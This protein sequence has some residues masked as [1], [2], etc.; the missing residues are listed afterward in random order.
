[1]PSGAKKRKAAKKKKGNQSNN[2][3]NLSS[4]SAN[5]HGDEDV[6][7]QDDKGSDVGEVSSPASQDHH[8]HETLLTEGEEEEIEKGGDLSNPPSAGGLKTVSGPE[9]KVL[10]SVVRVERGI[11]IEDEL[12]HRDETVEHDE[13]T[14]KSYDG[15]SSGGSSSR[16][17]S[18]SDDES[19]GIKNSQAAM[20]ISSVVDSSKVADSLSAMSVDSIFSAPTKESLE[21]VA[22]KVSVS[23]EHLGVDRNSPTNITVA[24]Y[25][26]ES[27]AQE[28]AGEKL[29]SVEDK[30]GTSMAFVYDA[31]ERKEEAIVRSVQTTATISDPK[32]C[33]PQE[34]DDKLTL[35]YN[36]P[37]APADNGAE[38]KKDSGVTQP[39]LVPS[40]HPVD[41]TSWK[42]CCGLFEVFSG[43]GA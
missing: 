18:S 11:K 38:H 14:R 7:H 21:K 17:S 8:H 29:S 3:P 24:P 27:V 4:A 10:E 1:M 26:V 13:S 16:S 23:G 2:H 9:H 31:L 35:P 42:S 34:N 43:S 36:A 37:S 5:T 30:V 20:D 33:V 39:L 28:N 32:E 25:V 15:G 22:E 40:A 6:K 41:R 19:H 12:G